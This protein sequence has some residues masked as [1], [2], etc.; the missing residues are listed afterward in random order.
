MRK[1]AAFCILNAV[2]SRGYGGPSKYQHIP[3]FEHLPTSG[4]EAV[5]KISQPEKAWQKPVKRP[6][7]LPRVSNQASQVEG[8]PL[9][10]N[11]R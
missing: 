2:H 10:V 5:G 4:K 9:P 3:E 8:I 1:G 11:P 7:W 6:Q